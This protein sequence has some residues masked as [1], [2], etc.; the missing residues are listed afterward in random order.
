ALEGL[1]AERVADDLWGGVREYRGSEDFPVVA[2]KTADVES[3]AK[4]ESLPDWLTQPAP[5]EE[6]PSRPLAP[7]SIGPDDVADPPPGPALRAAAERGRRLHALFERLPGVPVGERETA[8]DRWLRSSQ[9][10]ENEDE[11]REL[12]A[13]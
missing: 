13:D 4:V 6:R 11:R 7:S 9:G 3:A 8:A 12:V 2:R 10:V 5:Q 1:G